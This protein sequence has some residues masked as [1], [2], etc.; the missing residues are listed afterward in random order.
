MSAKLHDLI[1]GFHHLGGV[2]E[3]HLSDYDL[4][5]NILISCCSTDESYSMLLKF[6]EDRVRG[7]KFFSPEETKSYILKSDNVLILYTIFIL[8]LA[9]NSSE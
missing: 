2:K 8:N 1:H 9:E 3:T 4:Y 5:N 6:D 7:K